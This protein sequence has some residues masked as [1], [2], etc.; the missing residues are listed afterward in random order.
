MSPELLA[1]LFGIV[2]S[3][4]FTYIPG[5][6][7]IYSGMV[8]EKKGLIMLGGLVLVSLVAFGLSCA[9]LVD[10]GVTCDQVGAWALF[11]IF[12]AALVAN[13][14]TYLIMPQPNKVRVAKAARK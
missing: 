13:Q 11:K 9:K 6:N 7:T 3:L 12:I 1:S 4:S 5:W 10:I 2:L 14:G 8:A